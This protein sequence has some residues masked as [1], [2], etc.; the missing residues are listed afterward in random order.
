MTDLQRPGAGLPK[1]EQVILNILF[2]T[3]TAFCS[4][5]RALRSFKRESATLMRI[6]ENDESYDVFEPLLIPRV[7]GIEDS[8]RNWSIAMILEHL[9]LT[10]TE[11]M[12]AAGSLSKGI[13]PKGEVDIALYKPDS[14]VGVDVFERFRE[15]NRKYVELI[16]SLLGSRKRLP[17]HPRFPHPWFGELNAHQ[18]HC[19]A[20]AHQTIHRRQAQKIVAML[21]VT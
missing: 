16:E 9:C 14:D 6:T 17:S 20:A 19:L 3:G 15:T 1:H 18:W 12:I 13:V 2:K 21:G 10:N 7:I 5:A 4:D 11:M 8:S